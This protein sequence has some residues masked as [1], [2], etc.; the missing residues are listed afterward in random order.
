MGQ[1][2]IRAEEVLRQDDTD[3]AIVKC[4]PAEGGLLGPDTD[5]YCEGNPLTSFEKI[6]F[7][8][9]G[10]GAILNEQQMFE[11]VIQPYF[12]EEYAPYGSPKAKRCHLF[13]TNQVFK[14]G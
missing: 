13:Y 3:F 10:P 5:F 9:W 12:K 11:Q 1:Q 4:D 2:P 7:S 8:A 14:I 6:K